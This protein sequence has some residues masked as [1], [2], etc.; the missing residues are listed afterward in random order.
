VY[1]AHPSA[2]GVL[3]ALSKAEWEIKFGTSEAARGW[4]ELCVQAK[5]KTREAYELMRSNPRPPQDDS[6]YKLRDASKS[7]LY[8]CSIAPQR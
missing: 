2:P 6:H 5:A 3:A 1:A 4:E 8:G 7:R